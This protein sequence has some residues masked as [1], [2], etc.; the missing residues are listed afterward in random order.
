MYRSC[1]GIDALSSK[2]KSLISSIIPSIVAQWQTL[3]ARL[4]CLS[5][6]SLS[7]R[8]SFTGW[9][10]LYHAKA[11]VKSLDGYPK[12][13]VYMIG[14]SVSHLL[15]DAYGGLDG[16]SF[17]VQVIAH[18]GLVLGTPNMKIN[19]TLHRWHKRA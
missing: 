19:N 8:F 15:E 6:F 17:L 9:R 18:P 11:E 16:H 3:V 2:M 4:A 10:A 7:G 5:V 1:M 13:K 14:Q 12:P